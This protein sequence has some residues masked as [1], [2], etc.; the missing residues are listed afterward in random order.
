[1]SFAVQKKKK[2]C[3]EFHIHCFSII[4]L[5]IF[6]FGTYHNLFIRL[7][8]YVFSFVRIFLLVARIFSYIIIIDYA[9]TWT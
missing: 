9:Y 6:N 3:N 2:N 5:F 1:M 4:L 8:N 7:M